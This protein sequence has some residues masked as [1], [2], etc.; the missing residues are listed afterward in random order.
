M[1]TQLPNYKKQ[2]ALTMA[3][4]FEYN[5]I[6]IVV[7]S[8]SMRILSNESYVRD[9]TYNLIEWGYISKYKE[10]L[11]LSTAQNEQSLNNMRERFLTDAEQIGYKRTQKELSQLQIINLI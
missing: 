4:M 5:Q 10:Y 1:L 2:I 3:K 11:T 9:W 7:A 8:K 6:H